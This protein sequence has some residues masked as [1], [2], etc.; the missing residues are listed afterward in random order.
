MYEIHGRCSSRIRVAA[1]VLLFASVLLLPN[2]ARAQADPLGGLLLGAALD[3]LGSDIE[4]AIEQAAASGQVLEVQAGGQVSV[5]IQQAQQTYQ[6]D[7]QQGW[8]QLGSAQQSIGALVGVAQDFEH[9]TYHDL[10]D[11]TNRVQQVANT[12]PFS[13][14]FP[15]VESYKPGFVVQGI[16][17]PVLLTLTGNFV[18]AARQGYTPTAS[19]GTQKFNSDTVTTNTL[20]FAVDRTALAKDPAKVTLNHASIDVPYQ[21]PSFLWFTTQKSAHFNVPI[22]VLPASPGS[23]T[24]NVTT[25]TPGVETQTFT[26]PEIQQESTNDD[27]KCGGENADQAMHS[28]NPDPGGWVVVPSSV[29]W[30][31]TWSQGQGGVGNDWWLSSNCSTQTA[32]CLC[33]ST[34]HHGM[35]TSGKVHFRIIY[36]AQRPIT[37]TQTASHTVPLS[38]GSQSIYQIPLGATW[39]ATYNE[40]DGQQYSFASAYKN[41]FLQVTQTANILSF[42]TPP[43]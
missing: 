27:I 9:K 38:W 35:G 32:A 13:K 31:V 18:D 29:H 10:T 22:A 24:I 21:E 6:A 42:Q 43:H 25:A 41:H 37:N 15:Q 23:I 14:T 39:N 40:F 33:V 7:L 8:A 34:E 30:Q 11:I 2:G 5:L 26:T 28:V 16:A 12:L 20:T 4:Q 17:K 1:T 19:V 36:D 3:K